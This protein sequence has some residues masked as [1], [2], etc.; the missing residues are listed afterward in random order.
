MEKTELVY[1]GLGSNEGDRLANL[2]KAVDL[3]FRKVGHVVSLSRVYNTKA[4]GFEGD[5][6]LNAC[7]LVESIHKPNEVLE[8]LLHIESSMGRQRREEEGYASRPIDLD[9]LFYGNQILEK[10][11]LTIPHPRLHEREFVLKPLMDISE[12]FVHPV[13][14]ESLQYL[15]GNLTSSKGFSALEEALVNPISRYQLSFNYITIEGNIGAGKTT[16]ANKISKDFNARLLLYPYA[17]NPFLAKFYE[18]P[19]RYAFALEMSFL[20]ERYQQISE[21]LAQLDLFSDFVVSDYDIFKSLIFSKITLTEDEFRLYRKLFYLMYKDIVRPDLYVFLKQNTE[22][23]QENIMKRGREY[24]QGIEDNYL[25][26]IN[27]GYLEFLKNHP[28][29]NVKVIDISDKDFVTNRED[30]VEILE[31]IFD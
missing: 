29:L 27:S 18:D 28:D 13:K 12:E 4:E 10:D 17:D 6:F 21:D 25:S 20:A 30:Y 15:F 11:G 1:I 23:L 24:E 22:R 9:I 7:V 8:F 31:Y 2:Q 26:K 19:K 14:Q 5:H 3:I 16:L